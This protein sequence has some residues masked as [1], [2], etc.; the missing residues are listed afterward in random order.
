MSERIRLE[1]PTKGKYSFSV[2]FRIINGDYTEE[3][4]SVSMNFR[5]FRD[6]MLMRV[7]Y[8]R[9][10]V[11]VYKHF[12]RIDFINLVSYADDPEEFDEDDI[13]PEDIGD[14]EYDGYN[15]MITVFGR[16]GE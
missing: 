16:S 1:C 10:R 9:M 8:N 2:P 14:S 4:T 6:I 3:S 11:F 5:V 15:K 7:S 12:F 13:D